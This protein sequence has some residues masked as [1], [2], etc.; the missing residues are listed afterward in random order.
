MRAFWNL[1]VEERDAVTEM[2]ARRRALDT[3]ND[4]GYGTDRRPGGYLTDIDAFDAAFFGISPHEAPR[5][6]P[7]HRLLLETAW[8]AL[9]DAGIPA[10]RLAGSNTAV[11]SSSLLT[12]YW[13]LLRRAG[14]RDLHATMGTGP[15]EVAAGRIA[16]HLDLRG[17]CM[18]I[19]ASC[20][21]SLLAVHL[22]CKALRYGETDLAIVGGANVLL[23]GDQFDALAGAGVLSAAGRCRFGDTRADGY[24]RSEGAVTLVL[25]P[26]ATALRDGDRVYATILGSA[27]TND[28]RSGG[29]PTSPGLESQEAMLRLA[30]QDAG[31][32]PGEVDYV[33]AHGPGTPVG[34]RIEL[35]ALDRVL[36]DGRTG[37]R[38]LVGSVKSNLGHTEVAA[39][40]VGLLKAVLAVHHRYIPPPL[41]VEQPNSLLYAQDR[42]VE[43]ARRGR[44]WPERDRPALAGVSAF[45]LTGTNAH[46]VVSGAPARTVAAPAV[47]PSAYLLPLSARDPGALRELAGRWAAWLSRGVASTDLLDLCR[48][49]GTRRTHHEHRL[50]VSGAD[51]L[52]LA[53]ALRAL[54]A[55]ERP[56]QAH[57]GDRR[58]TGAPRVAFVFPG[59]GSQW[60]GMARQLLAESPVF[61]ARLAECSRAVEAELGWSPLLR[62]NGAAELSTVDEIQPAL[63]AIQV[64]LAAVWRDWGIEPDLV[65]GHSFGEIAAAVTAGALTV[66]QGAAV[67]CRRSRLVRESATAGAMWAVAL[68]E[69]AARE[70]I[71]EHAGEVSVAVVNS[72]HSTVLSGDPAAL[73]RVVEPLHRRGVFCR[74][75]QV[76]YASHAPQVDGLRA[77]LLDAL[78]GLAPGEARVAMYSTALDRPVRGTELD[79][80]Y[81]VENLRR[82]VGFAAAVGAALADRPDTLFVEVSPHPLLRSALEDGIE[83]RGAPASV[84]G[85]LHRGRPELASL[86]AGLGTAYALGC[87]PDWSRVYPGGRY[88]P[89]PGYPW[90]RKR[91]WVEPV[92]EAPACAAPEVAGGMAQI[93]AQIPA[94]HRP[95]GPPPRPADTGP[96]SPPV[97]A[98]VEVLTRY[99][100]SRAAAVLALPTDELDPD[101]S[102]TMVGLDSLLA[103][104][105][106]DRISAELKVPVPIR[107]LLHAGSMTELAT[108]LRHRALAQSTVVTLAPASRDA[109]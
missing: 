88:V 14:I 73:T 31:I 57:G 11:Y 109:G 8:E 82:P 101:V 86:L 4:T 56:D 3:G 48:S 44:P 102:L 66:A 20:A 54:A 16:Y 50:A 97:T 24:V 5:L 46:V 15:W 25:K 83:E 65:I 72:A 108:Q 61:A 95:D 47:R 29:T 37:D 64:A 59:Q 91:Y 68:G 60:V 30:Y 107:D 6:D 63:W 38:C 79:A 67:V 49:A 45:G 52:E 104:R 9:E 55:G 1:L 26:L 70:A 42:A 12:G 87:A 21:T 27:A 7:Q 78:T 53:G 77:G 71:G 69:Q 74:Q 106:R 85:S 18:G 62:V 96:D 23:G 51:R 75:V 43:L 84:I 36:G 93:P 99:L 34:D 40:L 41:H 17:P 33:E 39:G 58:T 2:P 100:V 81:W 35:S 28:G 92:V 13:D 105:L 80:A 76:D 22:A 10:E 32:T 90:Q 89:L 19:E 98:S 103:V 94:Q